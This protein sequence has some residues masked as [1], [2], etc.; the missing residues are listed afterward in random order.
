MQDA[1]IRLNKHLAHTIGISRR[2]ADELIEAGRITIDGKVARI[3]DRYRPG[4][5]I[6]LDG[7]P[8]RRDT[9]AYQY[10]ALHKPVGYVCSRRRQGEAPTIYELMP[11]NIQELKPI[12]RLDKDSSGLLILSNDGDFAYQMT[13]PRFHKQK[14]YEVQLDRPLEPLHRQ[15]ISE[16]GIT[17]DDGPSQLNLERMTEGDDQTWRVL[18]HEGRNRQIRRTFAALGYMVTRLHRTSFGPY[19]L[20]GL[21]EGNFEPVPR[22]NI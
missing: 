16:H 19:Q 4:Q 9:P 11:E 6:T 2:E 14:S 8:L 20:S 18:M 7:A 3:G 21:S 22:A 13:H 15:M 1:I 12:G 10:I 17:L 5:P